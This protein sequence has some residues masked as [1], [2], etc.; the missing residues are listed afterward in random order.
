MVEFM[1]GIEENIPELVET[2]ERMVRTFI[3]EVGSALIGGV[4]DLIT[5][6]MELAGGIVSGMVSG[7]G[8][9]LSAVTDAA[10]SLAK[11]ALDSALNFLGIRSPSRKFMEVGR[12]SSEG[13]AVGLSNYAPVVSK[14]AEGVGHDAIFAMKKTL[15]GLPAAID[16]NVDFN[17]TIRPVL[18]LSDIER[19]ARAIDPM[20]SGSIAPTSTLRSANAAEMGYES[21]RSIAMEK[22]AVSAEEARKIEFNQYNSSPKPLSRVEIYRQT[23]NQLS[24][25]KEV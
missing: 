1:E 4:D 5:A 18:D 20:L 7:I 15:S 8:N 16:D 23:R 2:G 13:L 9:G 25:M 14:A 3:T 6:G 11:G 24:L 21:N 10:G 17:P 22:A 19:S 12:Y